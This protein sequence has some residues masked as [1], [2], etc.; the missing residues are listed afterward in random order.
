M[1]GFQ[2]CSAI[3]WY[4]ILIM[5]PDS[6]FW[7]VLHNAVP[8][9][10]KPSSSLGEN[11]NISHKLSRQAWIRPQIQLQALDFLLSIQSLTYVLCHSFL[12][13]CFQNIVQGQIQVP[14]L[15]VSLTSLIANIK[16]LY[17]CRACLLLVFVYHVVCLC[18]THMHQSV[19]SVKNESTKLSK[20]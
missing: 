7:S 14:F 15:Q 5:L 16:F 2:I 20:P 9:D 18:S 13:F 17:N 12:F 6:A 10:H 1:T 4:H 3:P 11:W 8:P 19:S